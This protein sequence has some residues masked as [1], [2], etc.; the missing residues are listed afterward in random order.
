MAKEE[1]VYR[2]L[3]KHLDSL[4]IV[5]SATKPGKKIIL[6]KRLFNPE[7][8]TVAKQFSLILEPIKRIYKRVKR[9]VH[10]PFSPRTSGLVYQKVEGKIITA[11]GVVGSPRKGGNTE[12]LV[13]HC[14]KAMAE[15]GLKTELVRL[16]GLDIKGCKACYY[17]SENEGCSIKDDLQPIFDKMI[18]AD[19]LIIGSPVYFGSATALIKGLLERAGMLSRARFNGKVGGPLVVARRAGKNFTFAELMQWFHVM[20]I[21]NPG[22]DYWNGAFGNAKGEVKKDEEGLEIAWEFG[23]NVARVAKKL[24][25]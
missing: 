9:R 21:I 18:A 14:L 11:V 12:I 4:P 13:A 5:F 23:K 3:H 22:S 20:Q 10:R 7:K 25:G 2:N 24:R 16:A 15:E 1:Q 19:A 8:G 17:C 6:L